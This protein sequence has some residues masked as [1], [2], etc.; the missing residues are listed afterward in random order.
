LQ[1]DRRDDAN[2][3]ALTQVRKDTATY[4]KATG[5][6]VS[7]RGKAFRAA[8]KAGKKELYF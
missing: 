5:T 8:R 7:A 4:E 2:V 6:K 3:Q 1:Q